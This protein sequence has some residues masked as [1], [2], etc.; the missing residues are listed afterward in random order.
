MLPT[1]SQAALVTYLTDMHNP[2]II[3]EPPRFHAVISMSYVL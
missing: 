3:I 2:V 1:P